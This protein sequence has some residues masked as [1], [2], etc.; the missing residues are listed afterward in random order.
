MNHPQNYFSKDYFSKDY[1]FGYKKSN[2][3]N[4]NLFDN[5][6]FWGSIISAIKKYKISGRF[7]DVGCAL[8]FLLKRVVPYFDE[9]YGVDISKFA[10]K[11]AQK[12][13]P[14]S[15]LSI[16]DLNKDELPYSDEYFDLITA[17]DF[18]EHTESIEKSLNKIT[19][20]L[21]PNGYLIISL[22]IKDT[23]AAKINNFLNKD[24]TH[25]SIPSQK[26][27]S[28]IISRVGLKIIKKKYFI[29]MIFFKLN[30]IPVCVEIIL[31]K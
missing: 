27:L 25:V 6:G 30:N 28:E 16:A 5:N 1:F 4:Y 15:K 14:S 20:K 3:F 10:I 7:L 23:W 12:K 18:L 17:L 9:V 11:E 2:Y 24:A 8:G 31:Q 13:V 19:K 21:R 29:N 26:E 22:P